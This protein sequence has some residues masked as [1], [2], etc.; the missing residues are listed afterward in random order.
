[1]Q[2][3]TEMEIVAGPKQDKEKPKK[4]TAT[5]LMLQASKKN[6]HRFYTITPFNQFMGLSSKPKLSSPDKRCKEV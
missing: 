5:E 6:P 3:A 4:L 2:R 1:M